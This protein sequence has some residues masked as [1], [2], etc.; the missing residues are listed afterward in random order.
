MEQLE[1]GLVLITSGEYDEFSVTAVCRVERPITKE[2]AC[3]GYTW[4]VENGYLTT[5]A[6]QK[7]HYS[8]E[9]DPWLEYSM[10][11]DEPTYGVIRS[12]DIT[13]SAIEP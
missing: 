3:N 12:S 10:E 13:I 11:S 1:S 8:F 7:L 5:L 4:L 2:L 6:A 9:P